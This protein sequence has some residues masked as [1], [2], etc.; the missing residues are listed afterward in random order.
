MTT[1][2]KVALSAL[3]ATW[4]AFRPIASVPDWL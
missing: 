4:R 1:F 2:F 3:I